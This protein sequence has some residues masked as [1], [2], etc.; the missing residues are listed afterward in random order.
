MASLQL[1]GATPQPHHKW[2]TAG[3][4]EPGLVHR[5][6][7]VLWPKLNSSSVCLEPSTMARR[8]PVASV[9]L[10]SS[11]RKGGASQ[12]RKPQDPWRGV[13]RGH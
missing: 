4:V 6:D 10:R 11:K 9:C 1:Q 8:V 7:G 5:S 12:G 2:Q 3:T 13:L